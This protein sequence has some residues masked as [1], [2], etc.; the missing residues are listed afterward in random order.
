MLE[1][2]AGW[3]STYTSV[4]DTSADWNYAYAQ[5]TAGEAKWD[6]TYTSVE[7]NSAEWS[8]SVN[9]K[10]NGDG[11]QQSLPAGEAELTKVSITE[12]LTAQFDVK[13]GGSVHVLS[14]GEWK[15]GVTASI[16]VGGDKLVF[17]DGILVDWVQ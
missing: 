3:D 14:G 9:N 7:T 11:S 12:G 15:P 10:L 13:L 8:S 1:T 5:V 2:S 6:S 17:V 16:D 4:L